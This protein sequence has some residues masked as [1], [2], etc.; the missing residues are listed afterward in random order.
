[1]EN[2]RYFCRECFSNCLKNKEIYISLGANDVLKEIGFE[3]HIIF[4]VFL[5]PPSFNNCA[6]N[7]MSFLSIIYVVVYNDNMSWVEK[8]M[9]PKSF[10]VIFPPL[11]SLSKPN[12]QRPCT[13]GTAYLVNRPD[14]LREA[15]PL[16]VRY[17]R[18]LKTL[19]RMLERSEV[20]EIIFLQVPAFD[21][22]AVP[23]EKEA[24]IKIRL[25]FSG[26]A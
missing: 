3:R 23:E 4:K 10:S 19:T 13:S 16:P 18:S 20:K 25:R 6:E 22:C 9:S 2:Q 14:G 11:S 17:E 24:R 8:R 15:L 12:L 1:M 21:H 7:C 26:W 5:H